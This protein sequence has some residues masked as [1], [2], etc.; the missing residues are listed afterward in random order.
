MRKRLISQGNETLWTCL[1]RNKNKKHRNSFFFYLFSGI[2]KYISFK[3][4]KLLIHEEDKGF[5]MYLVIKLGPL[6]F[7]RVKD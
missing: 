4:N 7:A 2:N 6:R 1:K 5:L 3:A